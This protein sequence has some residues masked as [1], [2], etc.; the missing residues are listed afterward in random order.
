MVTH[1]QFIPIGLILKS[2]AFFT[3]YFVIRGKIPERLI[4]TLNL[5]GNAVQ[6]L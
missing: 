5:G 4:A 6:I 1:I 3:N 2:F